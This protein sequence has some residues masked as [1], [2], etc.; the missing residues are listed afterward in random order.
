VQYQRVT[1]DWR[2]SQNK[3]QR[4]I[5]LEFTK[6]YLTGTVLDHCHYH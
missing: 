2:R 1:P 4:N 6:H 3:E 5:N